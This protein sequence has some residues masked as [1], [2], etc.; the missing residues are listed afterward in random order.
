M[1]APASTLAAVA[2]VLAAHSTLTLAT[3][4]AGGQPMAAS[5]FFVSDAALNV[6][7]VS[8][9][10]SRHSRNLALNPRAALTVANTTWSWAEI[11]GVQMEGTV[12]VVAAGAA[13]QAVW[14]LYRAKFA[15]AEDFQA[16]VERSQFYHF[17]P[18]W[19]R[20]IDNGQGFGHKEEM[21]L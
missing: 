14:D 4:A 17:T 1:D 11:S 19:A 15:F 3:V 9:A 18:A 5:L 12:A 21:R 8:S 7:W 20:L 13:W 10:N 2:K 6:Y 16:I